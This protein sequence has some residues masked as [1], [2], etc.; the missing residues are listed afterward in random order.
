MLIKICPE[1]EGGLKTPRSPAQIVN[2]N[3]LDVLNGTAR[4]LNI[5]GQDMTRPFTMGA[6]YTLSL[7]KKYHIK[8]AI[9]KEKSPSCGVNYIYDGH[10]SSHLIPGFGVT[11]AL[12]KQNKVKIFSE[13]ELDKVKAYLERIS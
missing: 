12:L 5:E 9:L 4:V 11:A 7:V 6:E 10:F 2:G 3:G 13:N 8:I 1:I